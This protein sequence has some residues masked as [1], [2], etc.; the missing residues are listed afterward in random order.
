M[1]PR[2]CLHRK[3]NMTLSLAREEATA[4]RQEAL[5]LNTKTRVLEQEQV[6]PAPPCTS[7]LPLHPNHRHHRCHHRSLA[8]HRHAGPQLAPCFAIARHSGRGPSL[9]LPL[10]LTLTL[11]VTLSATLSSQIAG[12]AAGYLRSPRGPK[13]GFGGQAA[14]LPAAQQRTSCRVREVATTDL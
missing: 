2:P 14:H 10:P 12:R 7:L 9:P 3:H 4:A 11:T 1:A 5:A 6:L 8:S 13:T